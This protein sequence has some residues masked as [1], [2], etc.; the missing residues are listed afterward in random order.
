MH[1]INYSTTTKTTVDKKS[2]VLN[3]FIW[4]ELFL[5]PITWLEVADL[6]Q[7]KLIKSR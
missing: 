4:W 3:R 6:Q 1:Q 7:T 5:P 2:T